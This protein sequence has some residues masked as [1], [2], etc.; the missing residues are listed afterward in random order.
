MTASCS[1]GAGP[2]QQTA[3]K[4]ITSLMQDTVQPLD[5]LLIHQPTDRH[6]ACHLGR[7]GKPAELGPQFMQTTG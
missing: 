4:F 6:V 2:L 3:L 7:Y 5:A 1:T